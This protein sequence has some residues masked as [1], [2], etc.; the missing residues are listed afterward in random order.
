MSSK[1]PEDLYK[2]A[3]PI[4]H[5]KIIIVLILSVVFLSVS[6]C[7][8]NDSSPVTSVTLT[9]NNDTYRSSEEIVIT[10]DITASRDVDVTLV[11][12]SGIKNTFERNILEDSKTVQLKEGDNTVQF[13][14]E[15]PACGDCSGIPAGDHTIYANVEIDGIQ[16]NATST[17]TLE[18]DEDETEDGNMTENT[19]ENVTA[20]KSDN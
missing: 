16:Y 12:I 15:T 11:N 10:V 18:A 3:S 5:T 20:V 19:G 1:K 14:F 8:D 2:N 4:Y 13:T 17:V 6:G 9:T 7:T